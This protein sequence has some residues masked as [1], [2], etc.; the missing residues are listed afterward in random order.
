MQADRPVPLLFLLLSLP[1]ASFAE[2][3]EPAPEAEPEEPT[4]HQVETGALRVEVEVKARFGPGESYPI[5][6]DPGA[7]SSLPVLSTLRHGQAVRE[8]DPLVTL[9]L[10]ELEKAVADL[11]FQA[12]SAKLQFD[13]LTLEIQELKQTLPI[14]EAELDKNHEQALA[15]YRYF[16]EVQVPLMKESNQFSLER[17]LNQL[18]YEEEELEQLR[19]MYEADELTEETE[20]IILR[21]QEDTVKIFR[22]YLRNAETSSERFT[23]TS[24]PRMLQDRQ[25]SIELKEIAYQKQKALLGGRLELREIELAKA[26]LSLDRTTKELLLL[27]KDLEDLRNIVA[28][29]DGFVFFGQ[30]VE[31][32]LENAA[33]LSKKVKPAGKL[34][35]REIFMTVV[36]ADGP[37]FL[38]GSVKEEDLLYLSTKTPG[39]ARL[40]A[41]PQVSFPVTLSGIEDTR[42]LDGQFAITLEHELLEIDRPLIGLQAEITL[43]PVD[44]EE[45]LVLAEEAIHQEWK[46]GRYQDYVWLQQTSAPLEPEEGAPSQ[47][48][49]PTT[50]EDPPEATPTLRK[51]FIKTGARSQGQ[52]QILSGLA[53]GDTVSP[54]G[55]Q[56]A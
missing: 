13:A 14:R 41:D 54:T 4:L 1:L 36:A 38:S 16:Q 23:E 31:G 8:G 21:R 7:W 35:P 30:W 6:V 12:D 33:T 32:R 53:E 45:T 51:T 25:R 20:E 39:R 15:D 27:Q 43:L 17:S 44:L 55:P 29:I 49:A 2:E 52:V 42:Q 40:T 5:A 48:A 26:K 19:K 10:E 56:D 46:D 11:R 47:A 18:A 34:T 24:L 37:L 22:F 3:S 9:D 50:E 28:P